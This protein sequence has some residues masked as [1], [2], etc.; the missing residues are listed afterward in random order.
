MK[1]LV[2]S[3]LII[4]LVSTF[5]LYV[6]S[7]PQN[8]LAFT[9][10]AALGFVNILMLVFTWTHILAKKLVA[11]SI[12]VIVFKFAILGWIIYEIVTRSVLHLG[13]FSVG[14][15]IVVISTVATAFQYAQDSR[16]DTEG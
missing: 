13:W 14:L 3:H 5:L 4:A 9:A 15:G 8:T 2:S 16:E 10:G 11:L 12:G 6:F 7:T 1:F